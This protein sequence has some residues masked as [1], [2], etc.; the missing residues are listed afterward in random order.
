MDIWSRQEGKHN[1]Y[2]PE[3]RMSGEFDKQSH[4]L[5]HRPGIS[6][7]RKKRLHEKKCNDNIDTSKEGLPNKG[8]PPGRIQKQHTSDNRCCHRRNDIQSCV[9]DRMRVSF[10]PEKQSLISAV[11]MVTMQPAPN[12]CRIRPPMST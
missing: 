2:Q 10:S 3:I 4:R 7:F 1:K 8:A 11:E 5:Y 12:A 6:F 9:I